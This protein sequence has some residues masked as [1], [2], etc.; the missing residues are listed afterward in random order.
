MRLV[1]MG[2]PDFAVPSLKALHRAGHDIPLVVTQPDRKKGRKQKLTPPPVKQAALD[3]S[4]ELIQPEKLTEPRAMESIREAGPQA[5]VVVA[6]GAI[7]KPEILSIPPLGCVNAHASL[8]PRFR[9][10]APIQWAIAK[11][12]EVTGVTTMLMDQGMDTGDILLSR[13]APISPEDTGG[14]LHDKLAPVA[15]ELLVETLEKMEKGVIRPTPQD[16]SK[17][18]C[19]PLIK[20]EDGRIDWGMAAREIALRVRAFDPWPGT[21]TSL[22]G[23]QLKV[24]AAR[25]LERAAKGRPGVVTACGPEGM[26]VACGKGTLR[27]TSV[28]P[29]GKTRMGA[30]E[31]LAGRCIE[32]GNRLD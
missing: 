30:R 22:E 14:S 12:E 32:P 11:G 13:E 29:P 25:E 21:F 10:A 7:L 31:F 6:Y 4:L 9:G 15:G 18:T 8:L 2:T 19:A 20:K 23:T 28:Q 26:D 1:F 16:H 24:C 5:I 17:A 27:I 3:L